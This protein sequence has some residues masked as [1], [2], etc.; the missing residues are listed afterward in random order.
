M[1]Q[2]GPVAGVRFSPYN[3]GGGGRAESRSMIRSCGTP[4]DCACGAIPG[5]T[6]GAPVLNGCSAPI[7][8]MHPFR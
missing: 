7:P 2:I 3:S 5:L 1:W 8:G 6:R 4:P